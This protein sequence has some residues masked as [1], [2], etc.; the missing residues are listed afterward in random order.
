MKEL[1]SERFW[2]NDLFSEQFLFGIFNVSAFC[3]STSLCDTMLSG[4]PACPRNLTENTD[5]FGS[6]HPLCSHCERE[7][8][9]HSWVARRT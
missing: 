8:S 3:L 4:I 7:C 9:P 1:F 5:H 6:V 2:A